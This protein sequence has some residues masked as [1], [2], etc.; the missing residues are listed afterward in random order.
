MWT[1]TRIATASAILVAA[2]AIGFGV[3]LNQAAW[4]Q[5]PFVQYPDAEKSS[6]KAPSVKAKPEKPLGVKP[7]SLPGA[8]DDAPQ[9]KS[10][11][12]EAPLPSEVVHI[13]GRRREAGPVGVWERH[14]G[15]A[16]LT[17]HIEEGHIR[18]ILVTKPK[19][20]KKPKG[21]ETA[22]LPGDKASVTKAEPAL[23]LDADYSVTRDSLL[24][25][26]VTNFK[27][28]GGDKD[29][30]L[31]EKEAETQRVLIDRTF[32]LRF[33]VDGDT[34][35]IKNV[36]DSAFGSAEPKAFTESIHL[37]TGSY[38]RQA[39]APASPLNAS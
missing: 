2:L 35:V 29:E 28:T 22:K 25:G 36:W 17:L 20:E 32:S 3:W 19:E 18:R 8:E 23:E 14:V 39:K 30:E 26:V 13:P 4:G 37:L 27:I 6:R 34:L 24:Y 12:V 38:R 16:L 11:K 10:E 9:P 15:K 21:L 33:R 1:P 31:E 5:R 7:P